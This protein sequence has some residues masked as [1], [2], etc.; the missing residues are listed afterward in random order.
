MCCYYW[1]LIYLQ[2]L[3]QLV[4]AEMTVFNRYFDENTIQHDFNRFYTKLC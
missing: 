3:H 4:K 1:F 2:Y